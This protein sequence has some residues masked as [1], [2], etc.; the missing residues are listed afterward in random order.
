MKLTG[1]ARKVLSIAFSVMLVAGLCPANSNAN[2]TMVGADQAVGDAVEATGGERASGDADDALSHGQAED[3]ARVDGQD[4]L[5][6][7][8]VAGDESAVERDATASAAVD[9][10]EASAPSSAKG[11]GESDANAGDVIGLGEQLEIASGVAGLGATAPSVNEGDVG[12]DD[13][14]EGEPALDV[15]AEEQLAVQAT[16]PAINRDNLRDSFDEGATQ[17]EVGVAAGLYKICCW[18]ASG[19]ATDNGALA[20]EGGT[21]LAVTPLRDLTLYVFT[22]GEGARGT[23]TSDTAGGANGGGPGGAPYNSATI[24]GGGGGG[25]T[26]VAMTG[27]TLA[28][29]ETAAGVAGSV[30][31][32]AG[33]GGGGGHTYSGG[34]GGGATGQNGSCHAH[35]VNPAGGGQALTSGS[36][37][38]GK[39]AYGGRGARGGRGINTREG[40]GGGGGGYVGGGGRGNQTKDNS[41]AGGGGGSGF[42]NAASGFVQGEKDGSGGSVSY[43]DNVVATTARGGNSGGGKASLEY[44]AS[45]VTL[46]DQG[47]DEG[48]EGTDVVY[49]APHADTYYDSYSVEGLGPAITSIECPEREGW[50]FKGYYT[51]RGG[52]GTR[53]V[54]E[55]GALLDGLYD[56]GTTTLYAWW[57]PVVSFEENGVEAEGMPSSQVVSPGAA[58]TRPEPNPTAVGDTN[59]FKGWS[60]DPDVWREYKFSAATDGITEPTT[61]YA[62]WSPYVS[63]EMKGHGEDIPVQ[64]LLMG[65]TAMKPEDPKE[66]GYTFK[67]W[68]TSDDPTSTDEFD[69][70]TTISKDTTLYARW[71]AN[72]YHVAFVDGEDEKRTQDFV[73]DGEP[74]ALE[75]AADLGLER[76]GWTFAGWRAYGDLEVDFKDGE[77]VRNLVTD[78]GTLYFHAVWSR[79]VSFVSGVG[80]LS[81][82]SERG[83]AG[84]SG[85]M[86]QAISVQTRQQISDRTS[87]SPVFAPA[88]ADVS[89]WRSV[90]WLSSELAASAPDF[91]AGTSV[92]PQSVDTFFGLYNRDVNLLFD[93]GEGAT[94]EVD[95]LGDVQRLNASGEI[96]PLTF[97]LPANA[98]ER[99]GWRFA[100]WDLG[101]PGE[102]VTLKPASGDA[103]DIVV[104]AEW[105]GPYEF[106]VAFKPNGGTGAMGVQVIPEHVTRALAANAFE[107][108]GYSFA[109]WNTKEDGTGTSYADGAE[110]VDLAEP[111]EKVT[112]FAQW[113]KLP[114]PAPEPAAAGAAGG[115]APGTPRLSPATGDVLPPVAVVGCVVV[116][117]SLCLAMGARAR[118]RRG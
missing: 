59:T 96:T 85:L 34:A 87:F 12:G 48:K 67:G 112:L 36:R 101:E 6:A 2:E 45:V 113:T 35:W 71:A 29:F 30:L 9:P 1:G 76:E 107:R 73:Y 44:L 91:V 103:S 81:G 65:E 88:L 10:V 42:L 3:N 98:F 43:R 111:G 41:N 89:G 86:A 15:Q 62:F 26:H 60:T 31:V 106:S 25:A 53:F 61:L 110:V 114:E 63:F 83:V 78:T 99:E 57:W 17:T 47:A 51:E 105:M 70:S 46:D 7:D 32:V 97:V 92:T 5:S 104:S 95:P 38:I 79:D 27:G 108:E 13:G 19:G 24:A 115:D 21:S 93:G 58:A 14:E 28:G 90:G 52:A 22:G 37:I 11:A 69:F 77:A 117:A 75:T 118:R 20:S 39:G 102:A 109:G 54:S 82:Q 74:K 100:G 50:V 18:G 116:A 66:E 64:F 94:G 56:K 23:G 8:V 33:G 40:H 68:F 80:M 4:E 72:E 49:S 55:E 84:P 16:A